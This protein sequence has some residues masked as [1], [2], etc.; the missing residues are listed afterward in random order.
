MSDERERAQGKDPGHEPLSISIKW[1]AI[2]TLGLALLIGLTIWA[3]IPLT[4]ALSPRDAAEQVESFVELPVEAPQRTVG[5][6][7]N[8]AQ[9]R[10]A[11]EDEQREWLG[12]YAWLDQQEQVARIP[13]E[14]AMEIVRERGLQTVVQ[15][16]ESSSDESS[17]A[18]G[19]PAGSDGGSP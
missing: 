11:R 6:N 13:I 9:D 15:P 18:A 10:L 16:S 12:E 8:Q 14:R 5:L 7:P 17:S 1:V 4:R 3:M 2:T 19:E